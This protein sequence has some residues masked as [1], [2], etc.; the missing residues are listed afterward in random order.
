MHKTSLLPIITLSM[1]VCDY[2]TKY[3][4]PLQ[5]DEAL[6][7]QQLH[8]IIINFHKWTKRIKFGVMMP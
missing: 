1:Y 7:S 6:K 2:L 5:P 4:K 8:F 3:I